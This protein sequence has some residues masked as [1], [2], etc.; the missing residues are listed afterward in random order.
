M[1][2]QI[3]ILVIAAVA[4]SSAIVGY[5]LCRSLQVRKLRQTQAVRDRLGATL[6]SVLSS[7]SD[8]ASDGD[9]A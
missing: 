8:A 6:A 5:A 7:S 3:L 4:G 1:S 2:T 9:A